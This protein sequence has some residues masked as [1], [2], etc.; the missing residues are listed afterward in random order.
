M[1][2]A[3]AAQQAL[4]QTLRAFEKHRQQ[5]FARSEA[6]VRLTRGALAGRLPGPHA[7]LPATTGRAQR[8]RCDEPAPV[9]LFHGVKGA[10]G[11]VR[12]FSLAVVVLLPD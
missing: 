6:T 10:E 4:E 3:E 7:A 9:I 11:G 2:L 12:A 1:A 5:V 8:T